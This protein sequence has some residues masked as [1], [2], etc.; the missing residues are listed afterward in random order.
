M[1]DRKRNITLGILAHVDA[2]KTTLVESF[3]Y[4]A[5]NIRKLGRVDHQDAFLDYD[6]QERQ[7]GITIFSKQAHFEYK[8]TQI[9]I[10]DTP[11]HIDFSSEMERTLQVLDGAILL[12]NGQDG[13]QPHTQTIWE[14]LKHYHVPTIFFINKMDISHH[15]K[16]ELL[17]DVQRHCFAN[18]FDV[19][20]KDFFEQVSLCDESLLEEY[21]QNQ[22][23]SSDTLKLAWARRQF[24]PVLFGS[25]LKNNG[26]K[27]LMDLIVTYPIEKEYPEE[28]GAR[29]FKITKDDQGNLLT[30]IKITGGILKPK[31][32][33]FDEE[34]ID[35]IRLYN[36]Q[37]YKLLP[38]AY[39][40]QVVS[41]KGI[42]HAYIGQGLGFENDSLPG[43][44]NAYLNYRMILPD[45][46]DPLEILPV[47]EQ[48]ASEDPT[49]EVEYNE[50]NRH[51]S[52]HL[53]GDIQM[54]VLQNRIKEISGISVGF[55]LDHVTF[56]ETIK[57]PVIGMGH[58]E[59]LRH[60]AEVM[61]R[62]EPLARGSGLQY[63]IDLKHDDLALNWQR[64][65]IQSLQQKHHRGVLT[66]SEITDMKITLIAGKSHLKHTEGQ[67]FRQ[68]CFRA[69]RQGLKSTESILLEPY[70]KFTLLIRPDFLGKA[71][72]DLENKKAK[73][74]IKETPEGL[75]KITGRAPVRT[76]MNYQN[77]VIA[78]TKG[79]GRF[80]CQMDGYHPCDD[81][82]EIIAQIGYDSEKD[83]K[84]PTGSIF[85]SQGSGYYVPYDEVSQHMHI[86]LKTEK[87]SMAPLVKHT[88]KEEELKK[89]FDSLGGRNKKAEKKEKKPK[90]KIDLNIDKK[91]AI[92]VKEEC[93]IIDGYNMIYSWKD[94]IPLAKAHIE[95]ARDVLIDHIAN[96]QGYRQIKVLLVFDGYRVFNNAG[97]SFRQGGL[98]VI[99]TKTGQSAD[100]YIERKVH[101]LK[102]KYRI[103]VATNDGL[104][105]T[106]IL[107]N[108]ARRMTSGELEKQVLSVNKK[109]LDHLKKP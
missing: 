20:A 43:T 15:T 100:Q 11:G 102:K 94:L 45:H 2:G 83:L 39:A 104:I 92:P 40:G 50:Q 57:E 70:Y 90:K 9:T 58:F 65:I 29:V 59:P 81:S 56:K 55:G 49:L 30:H 42:H 14:C 64:L 19:Q 25:A 53:M 35:Q 62:M 67:D 107:A 36:G 7:R 85:F 84:N 8:E 93:L 27:E 97:S 78:Y 89:V 12:I 32:I 91:E 52:L 68:A 108:G 75:M 106:S 21:L 33:L 74:E 88:V 13:V 87:E 4:N 76:M 99:Y 48:L 10:L 60:Y 73:V 103:S 46:C 54:E 79:T 61:L 105:Q 18:A 26:V 41:L 5:G 109:A 96:Y 95:T 6:S 37:S 23:L 66:G 44:L 38:I 77:E 69:V 28:W 47:C 63:Q 1:P 51:I 98:D 31:Q 101:E 24:S 71:L 86:Q 16:E 17:K 80:T 34:K 82:E 72:Y 22:K 3:L